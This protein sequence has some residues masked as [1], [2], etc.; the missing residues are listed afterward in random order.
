MTQAGESTNVHAE[1]VARLRRALEA[2]GLAGYLLFGLTNIRYLTGFGG[3]AGTALVTPDEVLLMSDF[4]YRLRAA[5]DAPQARF[6]EVNEQLKE[7]LPTLLEGLPGPLAIEDSHLTV[8]QW[9]RLEE[10]LAGIEHRFANGLV[11]KLRMIKSSAEI[12]SVRD[13]CG[14]VSR[15]IA[16]LE[17][18]S[19][20]G[21]TEEELAR[22][23]E[24]RA[25]EMGS[26]ALPFDFIVAAGPR[27][28]MPH[29]EPGPEIV[30]PGVLLVVDIG[31][32]RA[33]YASDMTRTFATGP[34]GARE[35]E[36]YDVV[37][38]AQQ[39]GRRAVRP[40][41]RSADVDRAAR[42]VIAEAGYGEYF[43]HSLGHGVGLEV[44]EGPRLSS[45]S[46]E[47]LEEGMTL[48]V[49]PGIYLPE[50][51]GVRIEDTVLVTA[52]GCEVLTSFERGLVTLGGC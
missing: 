13:S 12:A 40:G 51:G 49:E 42:E 27:G 45:I 50:V 38:R 17:E 4:R 33:G 7:I 43:R 36:I 26:E 41:A 14:L 9:R 48:T 20:V 25:R 15:L 34:L 3:T 46:D 2:E 8:Q 11:E 31:T 1:R 35:R 44:H 39:V 30:P 29:A 18:E 24:I 37:L 21:R 16:S 5:T 22:L 28:A 47:V 23:L 52:D 32:T 10:G 6:V 19:V